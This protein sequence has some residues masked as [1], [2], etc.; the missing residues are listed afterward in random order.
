MPIFKPGP[1]S[2]RDLRAQF[3]W[4][5]RSGIGRRFGG[6]LPIG[7]Y[8]QHQMCAIQAI[9][10]RAIDKLRL[11]AWKVRDGDRRYA[12]E[13]FEVRVDRVGRVFAR[14]QHAGKR[15]WTS[16]GDRNEL[17]READSCARGGG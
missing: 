17:F 7:W 3:S 11:L 5:A 8:Q 1:T 10:H 12:S 9:E 15:D 6:G 4:L 13:P 2:D 14:R 16:I